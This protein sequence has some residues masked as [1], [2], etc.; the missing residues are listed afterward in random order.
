[1]VTLYEYKKIQPWTGYRDYKWTEV[2]PDPE[3]RG[4]I[5][6]SIV[7]KPDKW[8]YK[9]SE[10]R[11][12]LC[13]DG[14]YYGETILYRCYAPGV[15]YYKVYHLKPKAIAKI[16]AYVRRILARGAFIEP[17]ARRYVVKVANPEIVKEVDK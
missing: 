3:L 5:V 15:E 10:I 7:E 11:I 16:Q 14:E 6:K 17:Y 9:Y 8:Y 2:Y 4:F 13:K 1:M 12:W